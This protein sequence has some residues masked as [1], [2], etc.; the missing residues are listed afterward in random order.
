MCVIKPDKSKL[1]TELVCYFNT[2]F[3]HTFVEQ[4]KVSSSVTSCKN[5]IKQIY[6]NH[7]SNITTH[8]NIK[9]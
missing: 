5:V 4:Q 3:L 6:H 8:N 1:Q 7:K 2:N 9:T